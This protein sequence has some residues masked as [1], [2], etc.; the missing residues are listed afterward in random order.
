MKLQ[1]AALALILGSSPV[2]ATDV[3]LVSSDGSDLS[4]LCIAAAQSG[5]TVSA[6]AAEMNIPAASQVLC[7]DQPIHAFAGQFRA[8]VAASTQYVVSVANQS[9][10]TRLCVAA[11]TSPSEFASLKAEFFG[12]VAVERI[13]TCNGLSLNQFVRR[14]QDRLASLPSHT[15]AAL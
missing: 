12:D 8:E 10:E 15:T 5:S 2:L 11:L 6:L 9:P 4:K 14:Y 3:K 13:V 7:N 1:I